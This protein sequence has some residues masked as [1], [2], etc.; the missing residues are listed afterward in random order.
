LRFNHSNEYK[1]VQKTKNGA[2]NENVQGEKGERT[3]T[4]LKN[5]KRFNINVTQG[6]ENENF[7]NGCCA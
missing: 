3:K 7:N 6:V 4:V 5:I 2:G 1:L